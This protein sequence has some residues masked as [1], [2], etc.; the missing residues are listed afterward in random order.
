MTLSMM[1]SARVSSLSISPQL[2]AGIWLT[3]MTDLLKFRSSIRST[4]ATGMGSDPINVGGT[5]R[6]VDIL[7]D[8]DN[9]FQLGSHDAVPYI[10]INL[11]TDKGL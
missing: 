4:R 2:S 1:E 3:M 9:R 10:E 11:Y 8:E 6:R 7:R 5:E